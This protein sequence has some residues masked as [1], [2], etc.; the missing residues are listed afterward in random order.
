MPEWE[1]CYRS[2]FPSMIAM[3]SHREDGYWQRY[4]VD[5]SIILASSKQIKIDEK[6]RF[7]AYEDI[8]L[9]TWSDKDRQKPGW[10]NKP[11]LA[12]YIAYMIVPLRICHLLPVEQLQTAWKRNEQEWRAAYRTVEAKN[13]KYVSEGIPIPT[14]VLFKAI[15]KVHTCN[16]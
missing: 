16:F 3:H 13:P 4:G 7:K 2:F 5:R 12:D 6:A 1:I 8:L 11:I 14:A 9:E 10:I 15:G